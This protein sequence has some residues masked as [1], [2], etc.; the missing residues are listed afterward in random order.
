MER[1]HSSRT[2]THNVPTTARANLHIWS[3]S[4]ACKILTARPSQFYSSLSGSEKAWEGTK[5]KKSSV[6]LAWKSWRK[7]T[8]P[9]CNL[10]M[11]MP[12]CSV[13]WT[14]TGHI[15]NYS[16]I[17]DLPH[18]VFTHSKCC[19]VFEGFPCAPPPAF[20]FCYRIL[21]PYDFLYPSDFGTNQFLKSQQ[22]W[23]IKGAFTVSLR[24]YVKSL[25]FPTHSP[26]TFSVRRYGLRF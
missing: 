20:P 21:E 1:P 15:Y 11:P 10:R 7:Q 25:F 12:S 17:I 26:S 14:Q 9:N 24:S 3:N 13:Q 18:S 8:T 23:G 4:P 19:N 16:I 6:Y 5:Q 2:S 22:T